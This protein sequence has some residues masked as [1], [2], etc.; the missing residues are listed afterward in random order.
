MKTYIKGFDKNLQCWG[1]QFEIGK[2]YDTGYE[3]DELKLC[4]DTVFHF[5]E[6]LRMV[7]KYY[8]CYQDNRFC[9]IESMGK[10]ISDGE[11]CG[12]NKIRIVRE[13]TEDEL[14]KLTGKSKGNTGD[15]NTGY[16]NTGHNNTG[17]WNAGP[18]NTGDLN[19]GPNNTGD[20]N[21]GPNN[22]GG[23]NT[24]GWN[25]CNYSTGFFN[26][27]ERSITIFNK[28]S[29]MAYDEFLNSKYH[30]AIRSSDF[31]LTEWIPYTNEEMEDSPIRK[32]IGGYLKEYTYQEACKNWWN[33][34][35]DNNKKIIQEI[36]NFDK[37]I[38]KEITGI[39]V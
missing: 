23:C 15:W 2:I 5:C 25:S 32:C 31:V 17:N 22:T 30:V 36:P 34:M 9:E 7:H 18:N 35:S 12:S 21:T 11:K 33:N 38:F 16:L 6:S 8:S 4:T 37:E 1:F 10:V 20:W 39:E 3:D 29:G 24:G 14:N 19:T 13:I 27:K 28:D 26:T